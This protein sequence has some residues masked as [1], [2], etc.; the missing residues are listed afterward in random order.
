MSQVSEP[1]SKQDKSENQAS[2][3]RMP[4]TEGAVSFV[5]KRASTVA[6]NKLAD[7]MKAASSMA[8]QRKAFGGTFGA[9]LKPVQ[10][11]T[12]IVQRAIAEGSEEIQPGE[13]YVSPTQNAEKGKTAK[14]Y[15][16]AFEA[17]SELFEKT[18]TVAAM[19]KG[20]PSFPPGLK[21]LR[22]AQEKV[23]REYGDET[24]KIVDLVR[25]TIVYEDVTALVKAMPQIQS[26][27]TI[28]RL[29]NKF[30]NVTPSGYR[31]INMNVQF[32]NGHIGELQL[33]IKEVLALKEAQH[34]DV[35]EV[36]RAVMNQ[37][38]KEKG[39]W[40]P[41]AKEK[42]DAL[43]AECRIK[44]DAAMKKADPN[45]DAEKLK[46]IKEVGIRKK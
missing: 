20:V 46:G 28:V 42:M 17:Q 38:G 6:Q 11:K 4:D 39:K 9:Q 23:K 44:F 30:M 21:D 36:E 14:L 16:Q 10:A 41:E 34:K 35:Y 15:G 19:T 37:Y 7:T 33:N 24:S 43:E 45:G 29:K 31:D 3:E 1:A 12:A 40:P 27:F 13:E 26:Q 8:L 25:S 5:D 32:S 18:R 22:T 2:L